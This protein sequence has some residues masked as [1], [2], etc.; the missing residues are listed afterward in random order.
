MSLDAS[1][2]SSSLFERPLLWSPPKGNISRQLIQ[3]KRQV[4]ARR[5]GTIAQQHACIRLASSLSA[6]DQVIADI[7]LTDLQR[8]GHTA[9]DI[10]TL[11]TGRLHQET[12]ALLDAV[13]Q[14]YQYEIKIYQPDPV[15]VEAYIRRDGLNGFYDS[16]ESRK[17]C[18]LIRKI[19]PLNRALQ[20]ADAWITGQRREQSVTR[21]ELEFQEHDGARNIFKYNPLFDWSE[22]E[23]W[24][25]VEQ[26]D[27]P[28]NVLH[29]QGYPSIGCEPCTKAVRAGEDPRA[30]RWW[31]ESRDSKECGLHVSPAPAV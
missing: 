18:C 17:K 21:T 19:D 11:E 30:G 13:K 6:E 7:I 5:L 9:I 16:L 15:Q 4:L 1:S 25:Y 20:D 29:Y 2:N 3:E 26:Y 8:A 28:V 14:K 22:A 12:L 24:A 27:L 31:W 10:F 23:I